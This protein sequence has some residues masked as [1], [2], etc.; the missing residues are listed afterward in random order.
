MA[1]SNPQTP[2]RA[3]HR[4]IKKLMDSVL[5]GKVSNRPEESDRISDQFMELGGSWFRI[6]NGSPADVTLLKKVIK[7]LYKK[8]LLTK[9]P[10]W[11]A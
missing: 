1:T 7:V 9:S 8:G 11:K 3:D 10:K 2:V 6:F 4:F 5:S